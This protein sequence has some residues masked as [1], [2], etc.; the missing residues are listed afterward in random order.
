MGFF[1]HHVQGPDEFAQLV[2]L[3]IPEFA[4]L[5]IFSEGPEMQVIQY[6][7]LSKEM[8]LTA[9]FYDLLHLY[10]AKKVLAETSLKGQL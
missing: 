3:N 4:H 5:T 10:A 8:R 1:L 2:R 6:M 9:A 7:F